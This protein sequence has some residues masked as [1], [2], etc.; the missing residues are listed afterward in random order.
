MILYVNGD[1][2][3]VAAEAVNTCCFAEDDSR[4]HTLGRQGHP[5]NLAVSYGRVLATMIDAEFICNAESSSSIDRIIRTTDQYLSTRHDSIGLVIIG[6]PTFER[7]EWHI[8]NTYYQITAS[9]SDTVPVKWREMYKQWVIDQSDPG[10]INSKLIKQ[11]DKIW[12][13]H[14]RFQRGGVNH[15]FFNTYTDFSKIR[16][17]RHIDGWAYDW[18]DCYLEPYDPA[19]TY[20]NWLIQNGYKT[21]RPGSYHFGPDAHRAWALFLFQNLVQKGLT[22]NG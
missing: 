13:L 5:D 4:Y 8:D 12:M 2:H 18:R 21:V 19:Y 20:Y 22:Q 14:N 7:E 11:H 6:W 9:G 16:D 1:S 17:L 3:S 15:Y 10:V